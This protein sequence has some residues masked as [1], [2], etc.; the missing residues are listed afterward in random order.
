MKF[1]FNSTL[2]ALLL[3]VA[4]GQSGSFRE[5]WQSKVQVSQINTHDLGAA[6]EETL[7]YLLPRTLTT[8]ERYRCSLVLRLR[9]FGM[10]ERQVN[11]AWREDETIPSVWIISLEEPLSA[12]LGHAEMARQVASSARVHFDQIQPE[13]SDIKLLSQP[14]SVQ[15]LDAGDAAVVLH[16]SRFQMWRECGQQSVIISL[17]EPAKSNSPF[18]RWTRKVFQDLA[19]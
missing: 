10:P 12:T 7:D 17:D 9:E 5:E 8:P 14:P 2:F 16:G 18:V 1:F 11:V 3:M 6:Y 15:M 19:K 4:G 13:S